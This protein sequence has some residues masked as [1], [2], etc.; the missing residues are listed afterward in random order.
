MKEAIVAV[1]DTHINSM[2]GLCAPDVEDDE[3]SEYQPNLI[4]QWLWHTWNKCIDDIKRL[5]RKY[6]TT[7]IFN[8][9]IVDL[10]AKKRSDQMISEN[11]AVILEIA[12]KTLKPL[13]DI[14]NRTFF[15]RGTE[16]HVGKSGWAEEM[17]AQRYHSIKDPETGQYSWWQ[18]RLEF[19]GVKFDV[20]HHF[21]TGSL[22][23]TFPN[24]MT[25]LVQ[26]ERL[27]YADWG[28]PAPDVIVRGHRHQHIDTGTTFSTRG[29]ALPCWQYPTS[30]IYRLGKGNSKPSIG[31]GVFL[32]ENG[33]YEYI[34]LLYEPKRSPSWRK[35]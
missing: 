30:Y 19:A 13:L 21:T 32:C 1:A 34:P 23:Y 12:D 14:A 35:M 15:V 25:R 33:D 26:V 3:G 24:G 27:N 16:A 9:D 22:P 7:V 20:A 6:H 29:V 8:G 18:I 28:E 11:P 5:T 4:Q 17:M 2:L 31:C 10:D